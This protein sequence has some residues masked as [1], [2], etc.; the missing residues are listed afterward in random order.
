MFSRDLPANLAQALRSYRI[1]TQADALAS[2]QIVAILAAT[3]LI[4]VFMEWRA[5]AK[6]QTWVPGFRAGALMG[7]LGSSLAAAVLEWMSFKSLHAGAIKCLSRHCRGTRFHD[8]LG[9]PHWQGDHFVSMTFDA[10]AFWISYGTFSCFTL[11][12]LMAMCS[13]LRALAHWKELD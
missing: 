7:L 9:H 3:L 1:A 8:L 11:C 2:W 6:R 13:S 12:A 5:Y 4:G 10:P